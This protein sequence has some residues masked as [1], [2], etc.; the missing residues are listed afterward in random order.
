[1]TAKEFDYLGTIFY[2]KKIKG[3]EENWKK[4][5]KCTAFFYRLGE[6]TQNDEN[7]TKIS[8]LY[9]YLI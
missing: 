3:R 7:K 2:Q 8:F 5:K 9:T 1:M 6:T 4:K